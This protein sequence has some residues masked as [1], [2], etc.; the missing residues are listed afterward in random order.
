[1]NKKPIIGLTAFLNTD[2]PK[3]FKVN[4]TYV[5]AIKE[6]GGIPLIIPECYDE[7]NGLTL[8]EFV[9]GLLVP[10]G[11]AIAPQLFGEEAVPQVNYHI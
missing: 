6:A 11:Q 1:M 4:S 7:N 5:N 2:G 3:F 8:I 10:G 9:D